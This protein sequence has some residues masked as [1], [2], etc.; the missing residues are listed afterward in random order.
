MISFTNINKTQRKQIIIIILVN[1]LGDFFSALKLLE[2]TGIMAGTL[3]FFDRLEAFGG[4]WK[5]WWLQHCDFLFSLQQP[6]EV[7]RFRLQVR[8][9]S[10]TFAFPVPV[11]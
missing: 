9:S 4:S 3:A 2:S 6:E 5:S 10:R 1:C 11:S 7:P 8:T